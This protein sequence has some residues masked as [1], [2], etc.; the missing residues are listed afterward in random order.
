[1][2]AYGASEAASKTYFGGPVCDIILA[3]DINGD[4]VVDFNDLVILTSHW[5]MR[6]EDFVNKPPVVALIEPRD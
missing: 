3:G 5:M 4:C 2:G 1:M 6:G